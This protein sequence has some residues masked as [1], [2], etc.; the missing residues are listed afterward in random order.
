MTWSSTATRGVTGPRRPLRGLGGFGSLAFSIPLG[1]SA[2]RRHG[3]LQGRH[4]AQQ[5]DDKRP[6]LS[7]GEC[8][9][10]TG[11]SHPP[12][13]SEASASGKRKPRCRHRFCR[14]YSFAFL[15][16]PPVWLFRPTLD[17]Y[18]QVF[19]DNAFAQYALNSTIVAA[20][21]TLIGLAL[22]IPAAY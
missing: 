2:L 7:R 17:N 12:R 13:E 5:A 8:I 22:G 20:G 9:E 14:Y 4:L 6:Q 16:S 3:L 19:A 1:F 10:V 21:A 15:T 11:R 18:R